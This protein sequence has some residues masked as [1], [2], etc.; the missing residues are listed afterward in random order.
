MDALRASYANSCS[1]SE[2]DSDTPR[3]TNENH[4]ASG[5]LPPPPLALLSPPNSLGNYYIFGLVIFV[6]VFFFLTCLAAEK[7]EVEKEKKK[8]KNRVAVKVGVPVWQL[9]R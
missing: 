1:D 4:Q 2:S 7:I 6:C 9:E 3:P 8:G 5:P